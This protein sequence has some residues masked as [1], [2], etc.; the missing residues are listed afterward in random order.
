MAFYWWPASAVKEAE[1]WIPKSIVVKWDEVCK[2]FKRGL[3]LIMN[4]CWEIKMGN[5][6]FGSFMTA[7]YFSKYGIPK[8]WD[9]F[10]KQIKWFV[11]NG[12]GIDFW[13][14]T[15]VDDTSF[16]EQSTLNLQIFQKF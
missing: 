11:S 10:S 12:T 7:K 6:L 3:A 2:P 4:L 5:T 1:Q 8:V 13:R 16:M 14:D 9:S 15:W